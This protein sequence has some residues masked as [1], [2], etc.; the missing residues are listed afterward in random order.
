MAST[1]A[2]AATV[3]DD[4]VA[5]AALVG[6]QLH[7]GG[8]GQQGDVV[9]L[10][11]GGLQQRHGVRAHGHDLALLVQ[12]AMDALDG[13]A[14][15]GGHVG[16]VDVL[17]GQPVDG[18]RA[19]AHQRVHQLGIVQTLAADDGVQGEQLGGVEIALG[20]GLVGVPLR[21]DR[22]GQGGD[23]LVVGPLLGGGGQRLFDARFLAKLVLVLVD[24]L[25][26]VHAAGGLDGV[27]AHGGLA[28]QHHDASAGVGGGDGGGHAR[29]A[30][31]DDQHV[32]LKG[33]VLGLFLGKLAHVVVRVHARLGQ[34][35]AHGL[36]ERGAG[37]A[38]EGRAGVGVHDAVGL[39][40]GGGPLGDDVLADAVRLAVAGGL[41]VRDHAVLQGHGYGDVAAKALGGAGAG[42]LVGQRRRRE[43]Q[44]HRQRDQQRKDAVLH[45]FSS[46]K[47]LMARERTA[48]VRR[49]V[50]QLHCNIYRM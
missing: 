3:G 33:H 27:A 35:G 21:L 41:D 42:D 49:P 2:S 15:E 12:G 38:G 5:G 8:V 9:P 30:R 46:L 6:G 23:G 28:L 26:G 25:G 1:T 19:V 48:P 32:G 14:A 44:Q 22:G 20:V 7:G 50:A 39:D 18:V 4:A 31:A 43:G 11:A 47:I 40:E 17:G 34:R 36:D 24:G 29:A 45:G 13:R 10:G 16:Q 37:D